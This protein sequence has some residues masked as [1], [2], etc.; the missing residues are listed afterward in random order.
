[1]TDEKYLPEVDETRHTEG[2]VYPLFLNRW[3][4][5]SFSEEPV[6]EEDLQ[7]CF[8]AA[9][10]AP[11]CFNEQPWR[12]VYAVDEKDR[13]AFVHCL[14]PFNRLWAAKA[15][16]LIALCAKERFSHED[17]PNA[18]CAFD[19][20]AAWTMFALE[21][22][23]LGLATHAMAGFD[24]K[25]AHDTLMVPDGY[26]P[27]CFIALG[28]RGPKENL[29]GRMQKGETPSGRKRLAEITFEGAFPQS[30]YF[31]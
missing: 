18:H 23:R 8:R 28:K 2:D 17:T 19:C 3:S 10:W 22:T 16:V 12:F 1:M 21:A 20:G 9:R 6:S 13:E 15:P 27:V 24:M 30:P 29:P 4:P 14:I 26:R 5:R 25:E 31:K 11:S 7:S